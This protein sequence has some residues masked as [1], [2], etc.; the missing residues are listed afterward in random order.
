MAR[1]RQEDPAQAGKAAPLR[2]QPPLAE[3]IRLASWPAPLAPPAAQQ[4]RRQGLPQRRQPGT[5][6]PC[7]PGKVAGERCA[8]GRRPALLPS[9]RL[10]RGTCEDNSCRFKSMSCSPLGEAALCKILP[11]RPL[12][13]ERGHRLYI[14]WTLSFVT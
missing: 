7:A 2:Q 8:G 9:A 14:Y 6:P 13:E 5:A 11:A 3:T 1:N 12:A 4:K 10:K